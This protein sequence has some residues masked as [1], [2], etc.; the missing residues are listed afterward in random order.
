[1]FR[2]HLKIIAFFLLLVFSQKTYANLWVH[3]HF[4]ETHQQSSGQEKDIVKP[5][6]TCIDDFMMPIFASESISIDFIPTISGVY[7][8]KVALDISFIQ[9]PLYSLRGPPAILS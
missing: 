9:L 2:K 4:H 5:G 3:N 6:C 1:M 8:D 7:L